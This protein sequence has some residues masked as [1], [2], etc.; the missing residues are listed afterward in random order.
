[1]RK[2]SLSPQAHAYFGKDGGFSKLWNSLWFGVPLWIVAALLTAYWFFHLPTAGKA[3]AALAGFAGIMS[4]RDMKV[5]GKITWVILLIF[6]LFTEFRAIDKDRSDSDAK[7]KAFF[8]EQKKGFEAVTTQAKT[9]FAVTSSGLSAAMDGLKTAISGINSTLNAANTT[10]K[11][12]RPEAYVE[13]TNF[14]FR[15]DDQRETWLSGKPFVIVIG[16]KNSGNYAAADVFKLGKFYWEEKSPE[17]IRRAYDEFQKDWEREKH[18]PTFLAR[19]VERKQL[20][21]VEFS[22][23][24]MRAVENRTNIVVFFFKSEYSDKYGRYG[25]SLCRSLNPVNPLSH[26]QGFED[27]AQCEDYQGIKYNDPC[28]ICSASFDT[29]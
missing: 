22:I 15:S 18:G 27:E 12:T 20:S 28:P 4:V 17:G 9:D 5:L 19:D 6:M 24:Q 21:E 16:Y 13:F 11:Q 23:P 10:I 14:T 3:I 8:E 29:C 2:F 1:M 25:S 7:Q 26:S